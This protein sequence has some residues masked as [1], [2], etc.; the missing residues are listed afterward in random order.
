MLDGWL[1]SSIRAPCSYQFAVQDITE[2]I[3]PDLT[4][5]NDPLL[6][7]FAKHLLAAHANPNMIR[8]ECKILLGD[9]ED[10]DLT[11]IKSY[12]ESLLPAH[13]SGVKGLARF[14]NFGE[15]LA[16]RILIDSQGFSVPIYKLRYREKR[17][18]AMKLTDL[19]LIKIEGLPKPLVCYGEVKTNSS[20]Y[21][22]DLGV[23]GHNS[24]CKDDALSDPE[25][26]QF[27]C[28]ILYDKEQYKEAIFLSKL[29]LGKI[30]YE[31]K[32]YLFLVHEQTIWNDEILDRLNVQTLDNRLTDFCVSVVCIH[33]LRKIIDEC[34]ARAWKG[35]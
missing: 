11:I 26:L 21:K 18:W 7:D 30:E 13:E 8:E 29:R 23:E 31:K 35:V 15:V 17:S 24:L 34:Y 1:S 14:G 2:K 12:V 28:K 6:D 32:Y 27:F 16:S 33:Q 19:C 4:D 22:R 25:I 10:L 9:L 3:K 20:S 5:P